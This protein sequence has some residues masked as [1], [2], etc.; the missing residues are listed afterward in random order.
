LFS[1]WQ[2]FGQRV[3]KVFVQR[4]PEMSTYPWWDILYNL[5][6]FISVLATN[7]DW[8][9]KPNPYWYENDDT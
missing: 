1:T 8:F 9:N 5:P 4:H 7:P 3:H 2:Q 6:K